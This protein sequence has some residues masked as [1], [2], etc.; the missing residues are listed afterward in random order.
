MNKKFR[1]RI[2]ITD[3]LPTQDSARKIIYLRVI[4]LNNK[5]RAMHGFRECKDEIEDLFRSRYPL[6][7]I[8]VYTKFESLLN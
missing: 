3:S 5:M 7:R 4:E 1:R 6:T 8:P 2:K